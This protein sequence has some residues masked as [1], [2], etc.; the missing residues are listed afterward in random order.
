VQDVTHATPG[1]APARSRWI[2]VDGVVPQLEPAGIDPDLS[3]DRGIGALLAWDGHLWG[4]ACGAPGDQGGGLY[5][6]GPDPLARRHPASVPGEHTNRL[7]HHESA[8]AFLGPYVLAAHAS[9]VRRITVLTNQRVAATARH[10]AD[11]AHRVY[12]ITRDGLLFETDVASLETTQVADLKRELHLPESARSNFRAAATGQGRLIVACDTYE[13]PDYL[14][15]RSAGRLAQFDGKAWSIVEEDP[16][17]DVA[18]PAESS[19]ESAPIYAIGWDKAST[20]LRVLHRGTWRRYRLPKGGSSWDRGGGQLGMRIRAIDPG[21]ALLDASGLFYELPATMPGGHLWGIVPVARHLRS[22]PDFI[23][24]RGLLALAGEAES[25]AC[26]TL[27]SNL[28]FIPLDRLWSLGNPQGWGAVWWDD[29]IEPDAVSDPFL[30]T[31]FDQKVLHLTHTGDEVATFTI[32]VDFLGD[33][34]WKTYASIQ[35]FPG[36]YA[37]H[38]FPPGYAAHWVRVRCDTPG[39]A[40]AVFMYH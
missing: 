13:E 29:L 3:G 27:G 4:V 35:V 11:P 36:V 24:W 15:K 40:T 28:W 34:T 30:M 16:F 2:Q 31:G 18:A 33:G 12:Q 19:D 5:E 17:V 25:P 38:E 6:L 1:D 26:G 39:R 22:C 32:D 23:P 8:Q 14:G 21:R 9:E 7:I 37:H 20:V 10:L